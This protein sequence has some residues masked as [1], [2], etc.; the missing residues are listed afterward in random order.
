MKGKRILVWIVAMIAAV[1][2]IIGYENKKETPTEEQ[3]P[4]LNVYNDV[5]KEST[6]REIFEDVN[7]APKDEINF[8]QKTAESKCILTKD[9]GKLMDDEDNIVLTSYTPLIIVMKNSAAL[10][11]YQNSGLL[12][13]SKAINN[14]AQDEISIDFKK[15]IDAVVN[16]ENWSTFGGKEMDFKIIVPE[17]DSV[18]G[19]IFKSFLLATINGGSYP[20]T[21]ETLSNAKEIATYFLGSEK[22]VES[23]NVI[24]DLEKISA[25]NETDMYILFEADL[26]NST[27]WS[28]NKLDISVVYPSTTVV[29]HIYMQS[30]EDYKELFNS[31]STNLNYR[32]SITHSFVDNKNYNVKDDI[33]FI[34]VPVENTGLTA[35]ETVVLTILVIVLVIVAIFGVVSIFM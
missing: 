16:E 35:L 28:E 33:E 6:I 29:K 14:S 15:V 34:E 1:I 8:T 12:I 31:L 19:K 22:C 3:K 18:E 10:Q 32:T 30:E 5:D 17:E 24:N 25:I 21:T 9:T 7:I 27:A 4:M 23:E 20:Q 2:F 11:K 13:S 26:M